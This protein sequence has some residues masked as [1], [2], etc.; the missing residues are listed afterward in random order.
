MKTVGCIATLAFSLAPLL[1]CRA[2]SPPSAHSPGTAGNPGNLAGSGGPG[3]AT[4]AGGTT[5]AGGAVLD[6]CHRPDVD[7]PSATLAGAIT[8][9][10]AP[11][12][13]EPNA[14]LLL[15]N[16]L[17]DLVEIRLS[18]GSYSVRAAPGS[19]DVFFSATG[20]TTVA[21]I[22]RLARL[23][24]GVVLAADQTTTLDVDIPTTTVAGTV[25]INGA[26]L[27]AEDSVSLLLRNAAGDSATI[28]AGS[29]GAYAASIVPGTFDVFLS[30]TAVGAGSATPLNQL[31][32]IATDVAIGPGTAK[33]DLDV[34]SV[35]VAGSISIGGIPAGPS[36]RGRAYLRNAAGD[37]ARI[38]VADNASYQARV[39][40]GEYDLYFGGT[41][42]AYS[43]ANQNVRLRTGVVVAA[44][45]TT[46][47]DVE[48]PSGTVTGTIQLDGAQAIITDRVHLALRNAAGD[49]AE[50]PWSGDGDYT[51]KVVPGSY[52]L[53]YS[54]DNT[55][56]ATT[57]ANQLARLR[58]GVVITAGG[59]TV[60]D[61]DI[62]SSVVMGTVKINGA[63]AAAGNAGILTLR[64]ADGDKAMIANTANPTFLARVVPGQYDLYY[65]RTATPA[66]TTTLAPHNHAAKLR[67]G[68]VFAAGATTVLDIDIPSTTV[69]GMVTI[70]GKPAAS[71]DHGTLMVQNAAGDFGPFASTNGG[72]Y[73]GRLIPGM[74]D[75]YYSHA[76]KVGDT[77]PMNTLIKL[78]C[79]SVP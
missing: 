59:T 76:G 42:D 15:R 3:G 7:I 49:Y 20:P 61:L 5:G 69:T 13:M 55:V 71:G 72:T 17:N 26:P 46:A 40:P 68:L 18:G 28:P 47:L 63:P 12:G 73:T 30:S 41:Q 38:A 60:V 19:Y 54:K 24:T 74:Y 6:A 10:G 21:P 2:G 27:A 35:V 16:G 32:R 43:V 44:T 25:T 75:L 33:L 37:V 4:G 58:A 50:I 56:Q 14:R 78:R 29:G 9:N 34:P 31:A 62:A 52:D 36:N 53:Y 39:V 22:N 11:A 70:N 65:T 64:S 57:P 51:V 23:K 79:F 67:G 45:G 48:V 8:I 1:A 66:N 77:T